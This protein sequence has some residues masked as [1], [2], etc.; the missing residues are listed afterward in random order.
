MAKGAVMKNR[1]L[2]LE[3]KL[4]GDAD[5]KVMGAARI[6]LD[7]R[8][9]LLLYDRRGAAPSQIWLRELQSFSIRRAPHIPAETAA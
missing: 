1:N 6:Q 7:G 3:M 9:R 8:G 5:L 2:V 4:R